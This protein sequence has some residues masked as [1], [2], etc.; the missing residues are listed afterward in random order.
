MLYHESKIFFLKN[1]SVPNR[2]AS[3]DKIFEEKFIL[4]TTN[5]CIYISVTLKLVTSYN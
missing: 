4:F 5:L 2:K 3:R 1:V